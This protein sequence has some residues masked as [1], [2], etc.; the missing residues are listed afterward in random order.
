MAVKEYKIEVSRRDERGSKAVRQLRKEGS[1]PGVYYAHDQK[2]AIPFKVDA[3]ELYLALHGEALVYH[4]SVGGERKNVLM[5]EIQFHPVT[6]EIIHVDFMGVSMDET[7]EV[8]VPLQLHGRPIGVRDEGGQLH[9]SLLELQIRCKVGEIPTHFD[10]DVAE[11]HMGDAIHAED[12]EIGPVELVTPLNTPIASVAKPRGIIEEVEAEV[13][14]DFVFEEEGEV[15]P[16]D[17]ESGEP[18]E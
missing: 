18:E 13:E 17:Q 15:R 1:V 6:D 3:K 11:M 4:V 5:K 12:L 16:E 7:V 8:A 2:E 9:Q 14:E 10:V